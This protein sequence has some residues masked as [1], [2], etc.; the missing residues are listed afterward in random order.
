MNQR[1]SLTNPQKWVIGLS[2]LTLALGLGNLGRAA[3]ALRTNALLPGLPT[4]VPLTYLAALGASWGLTF[5]ICTFGLARFHSWGRRTTLAAAAIY[6]A[7]IWL[8][9]FLFDANDHARQ[10]W[11][12][13]AILTL[14]LLVSLWVPLN[15]S[16]IR[17]VFE[18]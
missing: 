10:I 5:I 7:H 1:P 6:E 11:P 14:L 12:R 2:I 3:L 4:T 17:K 18:R 16:T 15:L 13:D 9:H 8:N